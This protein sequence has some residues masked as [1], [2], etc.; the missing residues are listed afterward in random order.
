MENNRVLAA[1]VGGTHITSAVVDLSTW[2]VV[3]HTACRH[4]VDSRADARSV[5]SAWANA[6]RDTLSRSGERIHRLGMAMPGPFDYEKGISLMKNQ[7][8]Y[9]ALY[10]ADVLSVLQEKLGSGFSV[11]FINDAAAFLQGEI[12][13]GNLQHRAKVLG[14]TLGTGL[15]SAVWEQGQKAFDAGLWN[16]PYRESVF[17]EFLATRWFTRRFVELSGHREKGFRDILTKHRETAAFKT[18]LVEYTA[19]LHD[20]LRHFSDLYGSRTFVLGGSIS[21][22]WQTI[23]GHHPDDF[24]G[25][26]IH[27]GRQSAENAAMIG[28]AT[29]FLGNL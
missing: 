2:E 23:A 16:A 13:V 22:A 15:G 27:I 14:I 7:D 19:A 1:D 28:A 12:F 8:K 10:G 25:F 18:L 29:L 26:D 24:A 5:L 9:D 20:F 6:I 17:E 3:E 11:R 4:S 21:K